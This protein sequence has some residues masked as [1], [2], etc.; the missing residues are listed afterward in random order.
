MR[1]S[2]TEW[3]DLH[4]HTP[5]PGP[6]PP[7]EQCS[8]HGP[9]LYRPGHTDECPAC[10]D[11]YDRMARADAFHDYHEHTTGEPR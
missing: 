1:E 11:A 5:E 6:P 9:W 8:F 4:S 7:P 10:A 2:L 3:A